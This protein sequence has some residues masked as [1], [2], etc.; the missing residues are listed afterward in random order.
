M[1]LEDDFAAWLFG[2]EEWGDLLDLDHRPFAGRAEEDLRIQSGFD[3]GGGKAGGDLTAFQG[4]DGGAEVLRRKAEFFFAVA[5]A[6]GVSLGSD[7]VGEVGRDGLIQNDFASVVER[8]QAHA[9]RGGG[10]GRRGGFDAGVGTGL[11]DVDDLMRGAV[12]APGGDQRKAVAGER[13]TEIG[14]AHV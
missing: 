7:G 8:E 14:R 1:G 10:G 3:G 12:V 11:Q 9:E 5:G 13:V 2:A 6:E 4:E